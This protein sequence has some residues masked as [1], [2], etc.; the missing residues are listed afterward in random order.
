V[1]VGAAGVFTAPDNGLSD[2]GIVALGELNR[3]GWVYADF[4]LEKITALR[5]D[6][7]VFLWRDWSRQPAAPTLPKAE[8]LA[9]S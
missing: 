9:V 5:E 1:N 3:P 8:L 2:T 4:N 6:G 7:E